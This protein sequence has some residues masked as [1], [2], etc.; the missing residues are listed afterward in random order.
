MAGLAFVV[1]FAIRRGGICAVAA[2][3]QWVVRGQSARIRAYVAASCWSG[4]VILPLAWLFPEFANLSLGFP[5][6]I[7]VLIAGTVYGLGAYLNSACAFGTLSH[8]AGGEGNYLG[9]LVGMILGALGLHALSPGFGDPIPSPVGQPTLLGLVVFAIFILVA[10]SVAGQHRWLRGRRDAGFRDLVI[11]HRWPQTPTILIVS[12][13][14]GLLYC[15]AG[16]WTYMSVLSAGTTNLVDRT[17]PPLG[18]HVV[19]GAVTLVFGAVAAAVLS[20]R[21]AARMPR[22]GPFLRKVG[23]GTMMGAAAATIPGGNDALLLYGTPS[24]APHALAAYAMMML[25]LLGLFQVKHRRNI[26]RS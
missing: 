20:G 4:M 1:G 21:F 18:W 7:Y 22:P 25:V 14:G 16:D 11:R 9:T 6:T 8:L 3:Q 24:L 15:I 5:V 19:V 12:V 23:G 2:V 17:A 26:R 10:A 13:C